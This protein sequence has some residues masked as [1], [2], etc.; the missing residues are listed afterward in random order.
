MII[1]IHKHTINL[2]NIRVIEPTYELVRNIT[3]GFVILLSDGLKVKIEIHGNDIFGN[4]NW[5]TN[6]IENS[7]LIYSETERIRK[8]LIFKWHR[9][10]NV[11]A[12]VSI[13]KINSL[14]PE[15]I[16]ST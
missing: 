8:E 6:Q 4:T 9:L 15:K 3:Y 5:R 7:K 2:Q 16:Y 14:E 10:Y 12:N 11:N 1:E 13:I